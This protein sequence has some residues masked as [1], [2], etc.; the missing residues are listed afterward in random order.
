MMDMFLG[1]WPSVFTWLARLSGA[2]I[3]IFSGREISAILGK[4]V[5]IHFRFFLIE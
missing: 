2:L 4:D 1:V 3:L 5:L